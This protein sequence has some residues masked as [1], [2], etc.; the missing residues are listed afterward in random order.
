MEVEVTQVIAQY[1]QE[2]E[3]QASPDCCCPGCQQEEP[4]YRLHDRRRRQFFVI[5][6]NWV[7][8]FFTTLRRWKCRLCGTTFTFY[9]SFCVPYK[10]FVLAA[11][12]G[13]SGRYVDSDEASY[14]AVVRRQG[15]ALGYVEDPS[16][17]KQLSPSTVWR[18]LGDLGVGTKRLQAGLRLIQDK[19]PRLMLHRQIRPV[20][21]RKYRTEHRRELLQTGRL[22]LVVAAVFHRLFD[23]VIFPRL[24]NARF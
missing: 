18:W 13:L 3:S 6:G 1:Q 21:V 23:Q 16:Q 2:A 12:T 17:S 10:R 19:D 14:R 9:P 15:M 4:G 7:H 8:C 24:R 22:L 20:A 5:A 11:I